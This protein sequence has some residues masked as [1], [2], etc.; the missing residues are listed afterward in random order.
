L[1]AI[2]RCLVLTAFGVPVL[3]G[4]SS[5]SHGVEAGSGG[6]G[7]GAGA[8][9]AGGADAGVDADAAAGADTGAG[10]DG[11]AGDAGEAGP[12]ITSVVVVDPGHS[13]FQCR[14]SN[15]K[16]GGVDNLDAQFDMGSADQGTAV[17][18]AAQDITWIL[19]GDTS[20]SECP[21]GPSKP[22]CFGNAWYGGHGANAIGYLAGT[23]YDDPAGLCGSLLL[24]TEPGLVS[25][26]DGGVFAPDLMT[27]PTGDI[28]AN[29][30][31]QSPAPPPSLPN[32][33]TVLPV[34]SSTSAI[35]GTNEGPTGGFA[36]KGNVYIF[37][38]GGPGLGINADCSVGLAKKSVSFLAA[39]KHPLTPDQPGYA[40]PDYQIIS[41]ADYNLDNFTV[42]SGYADVL[43]CAMQS[44]PAGQSPVQVYRKDGTGTAAC[45]CLDAAG[46]TSVTC[47]QGG[48]YYVP[49]KAPGDWRTPAPMGGNFIWVTPH[50][51][52]DGY[53]YLFGTGQFR[54]S[55]VRLARMPMTSGGQDFP[56]F[57]APYLADTPG[58]AYW[59]ATAGAWDPA[60]ANATP[61]VFDGTTN[62]GIGEVSVRYFARVG[63]YLMAY[64]QTAKKSGSGS[65]GPQVILRWA[66]SLTGTWH[67]LVALDLGLQDNQCLY[68]QNA[69]T[70]LDAAT[71]QSL[72]GPLYQPPPSSHAFSAQAFTNCDPDSVYAPDLFPRITNVTSSVAADG[73]KTIGF[74]VS[75]EFSTFQP[76]D[77]VLFQVDLQATAAASP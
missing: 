8:G 54:E 70:F 58:L 47:P 5:A 27:A 42:A 33:P 4:C 12:V 43:A 22:T 20:D 60:P 37:Y 10:T 2:L 69:D 17:D 55:P 14:V 11:A 39:W 23:S 50:L 44:C 75:Y 16:Q 7:G 59:D 13:T 66:T 24:E 30:L 48:A 68:C 73:T 53:L 34:V 26:T 18:D 45:Q 35:S 62:D 9:G 46:D 52:A 41:R 71:C 57:V 72:L 76:Y 36:Y 64:A 29:Y 25:A 67:E 49:P 56:A 77:S 1:S 3:A 15:T 74:T 63:L 19:F 51:D 21:P 40:P 38:A 28:A 6:T 65:D 32:N 61:L 31:F